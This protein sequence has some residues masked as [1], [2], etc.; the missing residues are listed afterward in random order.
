MFPCSLATLGVVQPGDIVTCWDHL[1]SGTYCTRLGGRYLGEGSDL[2]WHFL[3]QWKQDGGGWRQEG[4]VE[5]PFPLKVKLCLFSFL[6]LEIGALR[7]IPSWGVWEGYGRGESVAFC[8]QTYY[9]KHQSADT[10]GCFNGFF[11][12]LLPY[13][14]SITVSPKAGLWISFPGFANGQNHCNSPVPPATVW[15]WRCGPLVLLLTQLF[16]MWDQPRPGDLSC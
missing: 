11:F 3:V 12:C 4:Q 15:T 2:Q 8:V 10:V 9:R 7:Q 6:D 14:I 5:K 13:L 1:G 16:P